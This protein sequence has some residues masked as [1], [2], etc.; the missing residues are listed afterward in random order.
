MHYLLLGGAG[1]IGTNLARYLLNNGHRVT[2]VDN[3]STSQLPA[4]DIECIEAD[5]C[6]Y[7]GLGNVIKAA[8]VV[9]FLAG[10]VG[11]KNV[12]ENPQQTLENNLRLVQAVIP[13][14]QWH[15]KKVVFTSTS[16]VYGEGPFVES[17]NLTVGPP[18]QLRWTYAA[19]KIVTEFMITSNSHFPHTIVRLFNVVGPGQRGDYGMVLPRFIQ[20]AQNNED[21]IVHGDGTQVRS[22]C[23][24]RDAIEMFAQVE[25]INGEVFNI[26][27]YEPVTI[28]KL[29]ERV[30]SITGSMSK[31]VHT[32]FEQV[33]VKNHGDIIH[34]VPD[35]TKLKQHINYKINYTL[36]DIIRS[37]L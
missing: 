28:T 23:H 14:L 6:T 15:Q 3:F 5:I 13:W 29:A 32:P 17:G 35:L 22:F 12:V 18:T 26:G 25:K 37:M 7:S 11:V 8:D 4:A 34:R 10:S 16:E 30:I 27:N 19:A 1:F 20:A 31:I 33:Y 21:I 2:V 24:V 36:D 9:Y